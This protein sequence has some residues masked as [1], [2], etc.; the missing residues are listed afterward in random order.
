MSKLFAPGESA[1]YWR[2]YRFERDIIL[3]VKAVVLLILFYYLF[4][5]NWMEEPPLV[6]R[7]AFGESAWRVAQRVVQ[8]AFLLYTAVN[9]ATG[10][11]L[12]GMRE[13]PLGMVQ[14]IIFGVDLLDA[15]FLGGLVVVTGGIQ[16]ALFWLFPFLIARNALSIA[17]PAPQVILNLLTTAA[18]AAAVVGAAAIAQRD[19]GMAGGGG[20]L[21]SAASPWGANFYLRLTLLLTVTVWLLGLRI[22]IERQERQAEEQTEM[23][24]RSEQLLA[25]GRLAAEIAHKL[26]NPLAIIN[27]ASYTLQR[28]VKQGKGTITQQI[29][30]IR[31]EVDR[32]DRLITELMGFAQ[33]AEGRV[34]RVDVKEE[35]ERAIQQVFPAAVK[36]EAN[37][38]RDYGPGVPPLLLQRNHLA[39]ALVNLLHNARE[40]MGGRGNIWIRTRATAEQSVE[41]TITDDGPGIAPDKLN[42]VFEPYFTTR[43]KG[44]GLGL[45]IVK[46]NVEI[47]GGQVRV[48]SELGRGASFT[49]Q[50]PFKSMMRL[51]K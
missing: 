32:S 51:R 2:L 20:P 28:T 25:S 26:K 31:E 7:E 13:V 47:Y 33:L 3:V 48:E 12:I 10:F 35:I 22:L 30:I 38:H 24:M 49:L 19:A 34:E 36:Y 37:I 11:L 16:S 43:E 39:E 21:E 18:Y 27:N 45:A 23:M 15:A 5:T 29:Q 14:G 46:H 9:V 44:S 1:D 41:I 8:Y 40:V 4:W 6:H 50:F 17:A 42:R